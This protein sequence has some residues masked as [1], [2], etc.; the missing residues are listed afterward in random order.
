G[1]DISRAYRQIVV[2]AG[3]VMIDNSSAFRMEE[4]IK[5]FCLFF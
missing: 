2:D 5:G 1:S 4:M 3:A